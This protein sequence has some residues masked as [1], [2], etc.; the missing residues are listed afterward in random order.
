[1]S[2][3]INLDTVLVRNNSID[4]SEL[5]GEIVMMDVDKGYY[6]MI[7]LVGS[8]IWTIIEQPTPVKSIVEK[9]LSTYKIDM[10]SCKD[11]V[12]A[13]LESLY[14]ENLIQVL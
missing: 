8:K 7:N 4:V 12:V 5:D 10:D 6:F 2:S 11:S 3:I 1:M 9:L 13:F 14:D